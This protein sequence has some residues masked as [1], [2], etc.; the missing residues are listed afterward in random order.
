MEPALVAEPVATGGLMAIMGGGMMFV[1]FIV[2]LVMI[3]SQWKVFSKAGQRGWAAIIPIYNIY[4]LAKVGGKP[5]WWFILLFI[6]FVNIIILFIIFHG[7]SKAF[8]KGMGYTLGLFFIGIIFWPI[9]AFG[10][11]QYGAGTDTAPQDPTPEPTP[12]QTPSA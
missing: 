6:P 4:V 1:W 5:G 7:I 9:L 3:V 10:S 2:V 11:A 8:G 12:G